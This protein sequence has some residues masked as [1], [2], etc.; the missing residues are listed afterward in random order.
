MP[1]L[2]GVQIKEVV[3]MS[4]PVVLITGALTGIGR[5]A[6]VVL[7]Q[8]GAHVVVSGRRDKQGQELLAELQGLGA[9]AIFVRT[10][11]RK[12][13][14]MR[15]LVDQTVKRFGRLDIAVNNAGTE[16]LRGLVTE[17]T[18]ESY[19]ATF[20]TNVLGVLL[21]MKHELRVMLPQGSGS[22]VN[23]SSAYGSVGAAGA[24]VYVA[25]KHAVEGLTKSAALEVAGTGVRVN[26]IA[27][28]TT[29]TGMLTRF[30]NTD[31]NKAAL[32]STVPLKRLATP[33]EIAHVIAFVGSANASYMTGSSIPVDGG[34]LA[35]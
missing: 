10:D 3:A 15:N 21:S 20:D 35:H 32:V 7:A 34:K 6:A 17:Q 27:V 26:V 16:G 8:E 2:H 9:E 22:I 29:D 1:D 12:D 18:A 11:V 19:A 13:E 23:V 28:G 5:A 25:S 4:S 31:E 24:S 30:T 14:D 33:E